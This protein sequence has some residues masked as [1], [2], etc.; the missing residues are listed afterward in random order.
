MCQVQ[1][2]FV[3]VLC[4]NFLTRGE[5]VEDFEGEKVRRV[6]VVGIVI[7]SLRS[8]KLLFCFSEVDFEM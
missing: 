8:S 3:F 6:N 1:D 7:Y 4:L 5:N 2:V